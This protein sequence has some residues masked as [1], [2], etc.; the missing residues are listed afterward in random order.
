MS[1]SHQAPFG[2][3]GAWPAPWTLARGLCNAEG[4]TAAPRGWILNVN[5]LSRPSEPSWPTRGG[6]ITATHLARPGQTT[7]LFNT[8]TAK[9]EGIPCALAFGPD[10][11]LYIADEGRRA[12]LRVPPEGEIEDLIID[13]HDERLNGANDLVFDPAGN[14]YF[15]DPWTSSPRNPVAGVYGYSWSSGELHQ[16]DSGMQFTNGIVVWEDRLL[17]AETYT[18]MVWS[19]ELGGEGRAGNR[20]PFC[21][22]PDIAD[23]PPLPP[24]VQQTLGVKYVC[25]PDGMACDAEG[26]LYVAHYSAGGIFVYDRSGDYVDTIPTPGAI[27]TNVCFGGP[28]H[29]QLF[30]TVDDIGELLVYDLGVPGQ[31]LPF[32]PSGSGNHA[33]AAMLPN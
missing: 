20:Q 23:A 26:R 10:E 27:P 5:S 25:G 22:L 13:W 3:A 16:I 18:R 31:R 30:V 19:Y 1:E 2:S 28:D 12:I 11:A 17:V 8:S 15:T 29:D 14:L 32:C 4:P 6:D 9:V 33:W 24:N 21:E 7:V